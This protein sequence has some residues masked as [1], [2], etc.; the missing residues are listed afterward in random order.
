MKT[1]IET[2]KRCKIILLPTNND[3]EVWENIYGFNDVP[4]YL[5]GHHF[6]LV[7]NE[8]IKQ[9]DWFITKNGSTF[10]DTVM[11]CDNESIYF[12]NN[13]MINKEKIYNKIIVTTD[14]LLVNDNNSDPDKIEDTG[15]YI[16][17]PSKEFIEEY[18]QHYDKMKETIDVIITYEVKV[19][20]QKI[21]SF[22]PKVDDN[23]CINISII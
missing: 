13:S 19:N 12:A 5:K 10:E 8:E 3:N 9:G 21:N 22:K 7:T 1:E 2:K 23:N 20:F 6:Y 17:Y 15:E 11:K 18:I 4:E 16:P 14:R